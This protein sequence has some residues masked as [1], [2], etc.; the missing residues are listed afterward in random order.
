MKLRI[1]AR[2]IIASLSLVLAG[3]AAC[4]D[5]PPP[6]GD[7]DDCLIGDPFEGSACECNGNEC[8]C[9]SSGDCAIFCIASCS[10]QCAGSGNC[11]FDCGP[12]CEASCTGSGNCDI[13]VG[14]G[15]SVSCTGSGD[16]DVTC[17]GDCTVQCPGSGTCTIYCA[18]G[19][20]CDFDSC[21]G[22]VEQCP[23]GVQV[24]QGNCP[25]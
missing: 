8:V 21:S 5:D 20:V 18:E 4:S 2:H 25:G 17:E 15:S 1:S 14:P 23:L 22:N 10:L 6:R 24:C 9:P 7:G 13:E 12:D 16:C 19:A 11:D 3:F